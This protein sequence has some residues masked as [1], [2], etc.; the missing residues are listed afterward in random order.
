V[1]EA[2]RQK[3]MGHHMADLEDL[4]QQIKDGSHD[5]SY[6]ESWGR[7][8]DDRAAAYWDK[9]LGKDRPALPICPYGCGSE[10]TFLEAVM[11]ADGKSLGIYTDWPFCSGGCIFVAEIQQQEPPKKRKQELRIV[12]GEYQYVEVDA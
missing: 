8:H 4:R 1:A 2:N 5:R 9:K 10:G 6:A 7:S 3:A 11:L 12:N